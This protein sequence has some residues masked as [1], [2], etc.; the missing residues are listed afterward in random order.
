MSTTAIV[1]M[2]LFIAIIWGGLVISGIALRR[3]PDER[4]G[5]FGTSPY[6]TDPVLIDQEY[7]R[8]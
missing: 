5:E 1:M 6:A 3:E 2:A 4:V 7:E 8:R